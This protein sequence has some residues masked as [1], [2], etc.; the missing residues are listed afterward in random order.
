MVNGKILLIVLIA[1]ACSVPC[2]IFPSNAV[3]QDDHW[4]VSAANWM[5]YWYY[6]GTR[7][8]SLENRFIVDFNLGNFYT[9]AWMEM[10]EPNRPDQSYEKITQRYLGWDDGGLRLHAGNFYRVYG[11]GL[12]LNAFYDDVIDFDNNLDGLDVS[13]FYDH[14][15]FDAFSARGLRP[16]TLA[17]DYT[18]RGASAAIRPLGFTKAGFSYVRFK[19]N[20]FN[21]F[22]DAASANITSFFYELSNGPFE[23]YAEY[24][25]KT[26]N[27][28]FGN[29]VNGDGTYANVSISQGLI[30]ILAEYKNYINLVYPNPLGAFNNPPAV[31]HQGRTLIS[32][33]GAPGERGYQLAALISPSFDLNFEFSFSESFY[34]GF[35][36]R[37]SSG[38]PLVEKPYLA[39]KYGKI[40]WQLSDAIILNYQWDRFDYT[41][42]D[43]IDNYVDTY[44][45]LDRT[46]TLSLTAY[47]RRFIFD[48][49]QHYHED[50]F[51]LGYARG[52]F[53]QLNLGASTTTQRL[54][55]DPEKLAFV[56]LVVRFK[57]HEL[58]IFNGGE[59]G[60]LICSS[61]ICQYRPTFEGTRIIMF[62]R[63]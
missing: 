44:F 17:R 30:N 42:E 27:D 28:A 8:D 16:D 35:L 61:G 48:L 45:Y 24:A 26:G 20:D 12:T 22:S 5:Q 59:R 47:T 46:N 21:S 6:R 2:F 33:Q 38:Q 49:A 41:P 13:G 3:A 25:Y 36:P 37:D 29:N 23:L 58:I 60:G 56:E 43:E 57:S 7:N 53:L 18:L 50:Y 39:E 15:E 55:S 1:A 32:L 11:R 10:F 31:S 54:R 14:F 52:N 62:S 40:R 19:Q 9:G 4:S 34:R 63:F 51:I